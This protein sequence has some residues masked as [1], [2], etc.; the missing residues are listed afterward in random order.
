MTPH[1]LLDQLKKKSL[2]VNG[3]RVVRDKD[4]SDAYAI[5]LSQ[6]RRAVKRNTARF[7]PDSMIVKGEDSFFNEVGILMVSSVIKSPR[8]AEISVDI[9]RELFG[10]VNN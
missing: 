5:S 3:Q 4:V 6:L 7:P 9:I 1:N 8:A 2:F 10:C